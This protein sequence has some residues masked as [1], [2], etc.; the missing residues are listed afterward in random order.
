MARA[1]TT[2]LSLMDDIE[3]R[4]VA[5][6]LAPIAVAAHVERAHAPRW[7]SRLIILAATAGRFYKR[8]NPLALPR[9]LRAAP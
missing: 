9:Q 4:V 5:H 7:V 2:E 8:P 3:R 1:R 6:E